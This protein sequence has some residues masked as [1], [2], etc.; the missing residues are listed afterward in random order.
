MKPNITN[1][2]YH[3]STIEHF[4][5]GNQLAEAATK[6]AESLDGDPRE[7]EK[8]LLDIYFSRRQPSGE[9]DETVSSTVKKS[10]PL[11]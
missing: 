11:T 6:V 7:T 10:V 5:T 4:S 9:P 3:F 2:R 1:N 8:E